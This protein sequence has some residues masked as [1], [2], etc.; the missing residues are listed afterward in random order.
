VIIKEVKNYSLIVLGAACLALAIN[1]F[2][3][4]NKVT[5]GG[6]P[7]IAIIIYYLFQWKIGLTILLINI[8]LILI[9]AKFM[10]RHLGPKSIAAIL[11]I[12][13]FTDLFTMIS[14]IKNDLFLGSIFGGTLIG[15][16]VGLIIKGGGSTGGIDI[17]ARILHKLFPSF[18]I[19]TLMLLIDACIITSIALVFKNLIY[20][21]YGVVTIFVIS[22]VLDFVLQD[23]RP[24]KSMLIISRKAQEIVPKI[25]NNIERGATRIK[26]VGAYTGQEN[27][28]I[29]S[30]VSK[31][32]AYK[33][34]EVIKKIDPVAFVV[35]LDSEEVMGRGFT[36]YKNYEYNE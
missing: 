22:R 6:V 14:G 9:G 25:L 28:V 33:L 11:L 16:G 13:L 8:P 29:L 27:E 20:A 36:L 7:G 26:A 23:V 32:E 18:S 5:V 12:S 31:Q 21:L 10:G 2:L 35:I 15:L 1:V 17:I 30:V 24:S 34:K 3:V 19:G 4:P